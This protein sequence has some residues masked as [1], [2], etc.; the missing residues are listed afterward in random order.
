MV[1]RRAVLSLVLLPVVLGSSCTGPA[2]PAAASGEPRIVSLSP[3]LTRTLM[4][5]GLESRIV[6]RSRWCDFLPESVPIVGDLLTV[7]YERIIALAPTHLFVQ[8]PE[9]GVDGRLAA[10]AAERGW[11]LA[12]W[13]GLDTIDDIERLV[14]ELPALLYPPGTPALEEASRRASALLN[15][16][17]AALA[18]A[19]DGD[20]KVWR[21]T[22]LLVHHSEP[23]GVSGRATFLHDVLVRL[24]G[25]NAVQAAGWPSLT[26]EDVTRLD[27]GAIVIVTT[28]R[29]ADDPER[30]AGVLAELDVAAVRDGRLAV[31]THPDA[32]RPCTGIIGVAQEMRKVLRALA[33][34]GDDDDGDD[35]GDGDDP[36]S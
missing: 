7:D 13:T 14:R 30:A 25:V 26:L 36:S 18:P 34:G 11:T 24:G 27:P 20:P 10:L 19:R 28:D 2:D 35:D 22:T 15:D 23:V 9:D 29:A 3:A 31:L 4:D 32:Q 21:G 12:T 16:I 17:A 1:T 33:R 5:F 6:G 8:A